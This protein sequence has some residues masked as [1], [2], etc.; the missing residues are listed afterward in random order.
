MLTCEPTSNIRQ[1]GV[2][3]RAQASE[4]ALRLHEDQQAGVIAVRVV[5]AGL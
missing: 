3:V 1:R 2:L 4:V 5:T